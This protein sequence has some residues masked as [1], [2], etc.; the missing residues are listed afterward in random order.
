MN[1]LKNL[2]RS[3][4]TLFLYFFQFQQIEDNFFANFKKLE[5]LFFAGRTSR[6][7]VNTFKGLKS[8]TRLYL[9]NCTMET[10]DD[11]SCAD[12]ENL[13]ELYLSENNIKNMDAKSFSNFKGLKKLTFCDNRFT[14]DNGQQLNQNE[15]TR[16]IKDLIDKDLEIVFDH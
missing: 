11:I 16:L 5:F 6:V 1:D 3:L 15:F 2:H 10:I 4:K 14:Y 9:V 12:F 8:L 7:T 13:R